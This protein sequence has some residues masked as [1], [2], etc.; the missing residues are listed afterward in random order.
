MK[1]LVFFIVII[2]IISS[3]TSKEPCK[4]IYKS[5]EH[6]LINTET[7]LTDLS[8]ADIVFFGE[9][10]DDSLTHALQMDIYVGLLENGAVALGMEMFERD[11]QHI[12]D[13]YLADS[14]SESMLL[15]SS[16][17]WNNYSDY[18]PLVEMANT[19]N[20]PVIALNVPRYIASAVA[21][22]GMDA[23]DNFPAEHYTA[24]EDYS[25][26][27][28]DAFA[29]TMEHMGSKSPMNR[30]IN[31]DNV[32]LAQVIKDATMAESI[33]DF[34][35]NDSMKIFVLCGAFHSNYNMG[36]IEQLRFM[37]YDGN[38]VNMA[39]TDSLCGIDSE[40][41]DYIFVRELYVQ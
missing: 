32:F 31:T 21:Y 34:I 19:R 20:M 9:I 27:Y 37:G 2:I 18:R 14:I 35:E 4:C 3:C 12:L 16:R 30:M 33:I 15:D 17:P 24:F 1:Q 8:S 26:E 40:T 22:E 23:L 6:I 7:L 5:N 29:S 25:M 13:L 38:I 39:L 41:A 28:R 10:H 11:I 36:I